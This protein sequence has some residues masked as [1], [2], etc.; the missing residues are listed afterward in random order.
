[1]DEM[2]KAIRLL[3]LLFCIFQCVDG[4]AQGNDKS[5][6]EKDVIS[7]DS[8]LYDF[9]DVLITDGALDHTFTFTNIGKSPIV[10]HNVVSTCGCTIPKWTKQPVQP[11]KTGEIKVTF[12]ND[13]GP[14][15]FDKT[16]TVYVSGVNRPVIL[17]IRGSVHNRK[18]ALNELFT[19]K[20]GELGFRKTDLSI[21]YIDQGE[22]KSDVAEVAN[23]SKG[24]ITVNGC[25][26]TPGLTISIS[27]NPIPPNTT[28]KLTY[29][30][31]TSAGSKKWGK[32]NYSSGLIVNGQKFPSSIV[33]SGVIK[34]NFNSYTKQMVEKAPI[35]YI[36]KSYFEF[37]EVKKGRVFEN[38]FVLKN[39]GKTDLVIYKFESEQGGVTF[40]TQTPVIIAPGGKASVKI[41]F[42]TRSFDGEVINVLTLVTNSP[43]KP[44]FNLFITGYV[45]K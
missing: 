17:K 9:G 29:M 10:I 32:S 19:I 5:G 3:L 34:D 11:S 42:D 38:E 39:T 44:L 14:Y 21:G 7:F 15:P 41:K 40:L 22:T 43:S 35:P 30:V 1:M 36:E 2:K 4:F 23:L 37:G 45:N 20:K 25:D 24:E 13:Q 18:M 33:V 16:L 31:N 12:K 27:P 6:N 28:A 8:K 26:A